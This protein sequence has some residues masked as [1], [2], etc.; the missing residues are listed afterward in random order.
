MVSPVRESR[1][2]NAPRTLRDGRLEGVLLGFP[3]NQ[4]FVFLAIRHLLLGDSHEVE[5]IP[6]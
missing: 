5:L 2:K 3:L 1:R 4:N 6:L